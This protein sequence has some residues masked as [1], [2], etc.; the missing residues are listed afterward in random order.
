MCSIA[1]IAAWRTRPTPQR[2]GGGT[3]G[4][5]PPS[6]AYGRPAS[7]RSAIPMQAPTRTLRCRQQWDA[8]VV[9]L[10]EYM[11]YDVGAI[12]PAGYDPQAVPR[13][14]VFARRLHRVP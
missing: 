14:P 8:Y 3:P 7:G 10:S 4:I 2:G 9:A 1:A 13:R 5:T 11:A 12:D 6:A